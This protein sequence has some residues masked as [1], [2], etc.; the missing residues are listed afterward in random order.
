MENLDL[1]I[2]ELENIKKRKRGSGIESS[3][4]EA[5]EHSLYKI[6]RADYDK[7]ILKNKKRKLEALDSKEQVQ[8]LKNPIKTLS[9][10]GSFIGYEV[11]ANPYDIVWDTKSLPLEIKINL[12]QDLKE[13]LAILAANGVIYMDL[14]KRNL[15]IDKSTG[16]LSFCDIDS[17]Q[18]DNIPSDV[19]LTSVKSE[20]DLYNQSAHIY[21]HNL[22]TLD[23]LT[24]QVGDYDF[25]LKSL[26]YESKGDIRKTCPF[27]HKGSRIVKQ[28][29]K[30]K[31]MAP[32]VYLIDNLKKVS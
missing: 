8:F 15:L 24:M 26:S 4:Y 25:L 23:E 29:T 2:K 12:L 16:Q 7:E 19:T 5:T 27:N 9:L 21:L 3:I 13:K 10:N 31:R 20:N 14:R 18:V 6:F 30:C 17:A 11:E 32:K 22:F 1:T 28:M